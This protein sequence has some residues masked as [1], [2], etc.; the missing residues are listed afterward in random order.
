[1]G[2]PAGRII[3]CPRPADARG[4][5]RASDDREGHAL[6]ATTLLALAS[7]VGAIELDDPVHFQ[8]KRYTSFELNFLGEWPGGVGGSET[9]YDLDGFVLSPR[10]CAARPGS[11]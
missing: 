5:P 6:L 11:V 10:L 3:R 1:M 7:R 4:P 2:G 8:V 9:S